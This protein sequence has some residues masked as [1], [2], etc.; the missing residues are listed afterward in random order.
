L[1]RTQD[2]DQHDDPNDV[3]D[4][5]SSDESTDESDDGDE[6][7]TSTATFTADSDELNVT[8]QGSDPN[9]EDECEAPRDNTDIISSDEE[10]EYDDEEILDRSVI[11]ENI[12]HILSSCRKIV[13]GINRSS[14]LYETVQ[15]LA[16]PTVKGDLILDMRIRWNSTCNMILRLIEYRPILTAF[17]NQLPSIRGPTPKKKKKLLKLQLSDM[18]WNVLDTLK[19]ALELFSDASDMLSGS[20][21]PSL[22]MA[23]P[24]IDS[25][26][27]YLQSTSTDDIENTIKYVLNGTFHKYVYHPIDSPEHNLLLV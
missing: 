23:Y 10:M 2:N 7:E 22:A 6:E 27:H 5:E 15:N 25:L 13:N 3:E 12:N 20:N 19:P 24:V 26:Y 17:M 9:D 14:I 4:E 21:Y 16:R 18:E 11:L 8:T 1:F